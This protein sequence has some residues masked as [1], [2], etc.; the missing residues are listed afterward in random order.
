M[1][2]SDYLEI[3][4]NKIINKK[5]NMIRSSSNRTKNNQYYYLQNISTTNEDGDLMKQKRFNITLPNNCNFY[6][7]IDNKLASRFS[8]MFSIPKI[9]SIYE[10][11]RYQP[12]FC[13]TCYS[14]IGEI[15]NSIAC[16]VCDKSP[17]YYDV[18][19]ITDEQRKILDNIDNIINEFDKTHFNIDNIDNII[20]EFDN[21]NLETI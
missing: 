15:T 8:F 4:K 19:T 1:A 11:N 13:W 2:Y 18:K 6:S 3:K 12:A 14:S 20:D 10:K 16:S 7:K 17:S 5:N 9:L 21:D